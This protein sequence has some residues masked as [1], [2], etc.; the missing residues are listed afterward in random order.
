ME[1]P[2][3]LQT[4]LF[5]PAGLAPGDVVWL[6]GG[7]YYKNNQLTRFTSTL[8]GA[9]GQPIT[10]RQFP[11]ERAII[12]GNLFQQSGGWVQ[13]W[14]F[15]IMNS[16][17]NRVTTEAG[18]FPTA[19]Y[20][21]SGGQTNDWV[22]SG[23]DLRAPNVKLINLVV[24]DSI[25]GGISANVAAT[26][27]EV[28]G[29][30][31]Y[32][33]GWQGCDRGHGHG[34]YIQSKDPSRATIS[35][36]LFF[37]NYGLGVQATANQDGVDNISFEG[38]AIFSNG[39]LARKHQ[40]NLLIGSVVGLARNPVL[41]SNFIFDAFGSSS[42]SNIGYSGGSTSAVV[43]G[44]YFQT[45]VYFSQ[46]SE[47]MILISN[48]FLSGTTFLDRTNH[49]NN[50]FMEKLPLNMVV[51]VRTNKY[52]PGR[53]TII[54]YNWENQESIGVD[55]GSFLPLGTPFAVRNAQNFRGPPLLNGTFEGELIYLPLRNLP[56]AKPIGINAPASTS[57]AF[58][59]FIIQP[60]EQS[61]DPTFSNSP[62]TISSIPGQATYENSESEPIPFV[63]QD[64]ETPAAYLNLSVHSSN[65]DLVPH[66]NIRIEGTGTNR[67]VTIMPASDRTGSTDITLVASDGFMYAKTAFNVQ[68]FP[69]TTPPT[70]AHHT[71][72]QLSISLVEF[73]A[74]IQIHGIPDVDYQIQSSTNL[75]NWQFFG[76]ISTD[77]QGVGKFVD[78]HLEDAFARYYRLVLPTTE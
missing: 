78:H 51:K 1:A 39:I 64:S 5:H 56:V 19:F 72:L 68:V 14:G 50:I 18:S 15:E 30:L 2:W 7:I 75:I 45:S 43:V 3:D 67:T 58:N 65:S 55:L 37:A 70:Q 62:P 28:Y 48:T 29:T 77:C 11:G 9:P 21:G 44:N 66:K 42:D 60:A 13:Y 36:N 33:N 4:A 6:R 71:P 49:P 17:P 73:D 16:H 47:G 54:V 63:M 27:P 8:A 23:F 74:A 57:P 53:A 32:Y 35:E 52:E 22:V 26:D 24:H 76:T 41:I 46:H 20:I 25:G 40:G 61:P 12:D 69:Q 34:L 31:S 10:V 38:N 59:I